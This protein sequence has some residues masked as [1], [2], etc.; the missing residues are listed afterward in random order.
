MQHFREY[1]KTLLSDVY[2]EEEIHVFTYTV[3]EKITGYTKTHLLADKNIIL[4]ESQKNDAEEM[5]LRLKKGEPIQYILGE[6]KFF[7]LKFTVNPSVLIPRPETEELV[8]WILNDLP[9]NPLKG[10]YLDVGTGSGCIAI[11]LKKHL[12][13]ATVSAIDISADAL[14]IAK[15]NAKLNDVK[16]DFIQKDILKTDILDKKY[17]IIVSNPPYVPQNDKQEM[18]SNVLDYEPH[19]ALFVEDNNPLVF[20]RKIAELAKNNLTKHGALY[21]EIHKNQGENCQRMLS[22]LGFKNIQIKKDISGNDRMIK[23]NV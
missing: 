12:P 10:E 8:Q 7:G 2:S 11:S 13:N 3:L 5:V 19:I 21:F 15:E 6:T 18:H 17:D 22:S 16:I 9:P 4:S 1:I 23:A 14:K 20:Y